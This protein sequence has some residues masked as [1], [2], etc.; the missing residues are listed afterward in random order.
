MN[1]VERLLEEHRQMERQLEELEMSMSE[2]EEPLNVSHITNVFR[3]LHN[4]WNEHEKKEEDFFIRLK[5]EGASLPFEKVLFEHQELR[6]HKKVLND[7]INS[8]SDIRI[9]V[10]LD[11][12]GRMLINKLRKHIEDEEES[13]LNNSLNINQIKNLSR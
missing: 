1:S 9:M 2:D 10:A 7:A 3:K 11:T 13:I 12:D 6:G 4:L 5:N 8:G